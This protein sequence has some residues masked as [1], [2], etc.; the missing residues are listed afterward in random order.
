MSRRRQKK[1]RENPTLE[2]NMTAM[3]DVVFQLLIYL[4]L[5]AKPMDVIAHLDILRPQTDAVAPPNEEV[6]DLVQVMIFRD[7][8]FI[9]EKQVSAKTLE[10]V[11]EKLAALSTTQTVLIKCAP[12]SPHDRLVH[13]LD[14]CSKVKLTNLSVMSM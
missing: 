9:N 6:R 13:V 11:L 14:L 5:T 3:C 7:T 8:Y 10:T 4:I 1:R 12:D 2:L